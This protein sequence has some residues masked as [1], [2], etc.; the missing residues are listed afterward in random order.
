MGLVQ[1]LLRGRITLAFKTIFFLCQSLARPLLLLLEVRNILAIKETN[2][3]DT[4]GNLS[5]VN[6][7]IDQTDVSG[8]PQRIAD[9]IK[10]AAVKTG[11]SFSY[12]MHKAAQESGFDPNAK[13]SSSSATGL[14]QFTSQTW[15]QMVK[16]HG[17]DYGLSN[18]A[19]KIQ[20][21]S[22]GVAHASDATTRQAILAL[23][24]D[25][26]ISAEMAGELD[27]E[28]LSSLKS[29]VGG[30]IGATDLYLAHFL[31]AAGASDF[32]NKMKANPSANAAAILPDAAASNPSVFYTSSGDARSLSQIY[33]HFAQ[34]FEGGS[35]TMVASIT[36]Q[37]KVQTQHALPQ[38]TPTYTLASAANTSNAVS[39]LGAA[40][41]PYAGSNYLTQVGTNSTK[42]TSASLLNTMI[43]AQMNATTADS[44]ESIQSAYGATGLNNQN[45]KSAIDVLGSIA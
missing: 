33:N 16:A 25:P 44:M 7:L 41:K 5:S 8:L 37:T 42:S 38:S 35:A 40:T 3:V 6:S 13:A 28:N 23:R 30:K 10:T 15:L 4:I 32:L 1:R 12:L 14:F 18:Y 20:V 27:K 2:L 21:D 34:K 9:A 31:G 19:N 39:I 17:A 45:K 36:P 22:N 26:Q 11:V 43:L 24:N 29:N